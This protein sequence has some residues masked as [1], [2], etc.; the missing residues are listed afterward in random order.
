[1][2]NQLIISIGREFGSGGH[3]IAQSLSDI[4][5]IDL[6]DQ[7]LL[8]QVAG[9]YHLD[10]GELRALDEKRKNHLLARTVLGM[11]NSP[12]ENVANLQF[13]FLRKKAEAGESFVV[14]GRCSDCIL[15]EYPGFISV[16]ILGDTD[17]KLERIMELYHLSRNKAF[18]LME[19]NDRKRK[20]YH[21]SHC[22]IKWGDSRGYDLSVNSSKLGIQGSVKLIC[23]YIDMRNKIRQS[24]N[25]PL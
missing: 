21:N 16:F 22:E 11:T 14:V 13:Q 19:E 1:M 10:S 18:V 23:E 9:E 17:R 24:D 7:N 8:E 3:E 4:Y 12:A 5:H 2:E 15:K 25:K 20:K 6:Y